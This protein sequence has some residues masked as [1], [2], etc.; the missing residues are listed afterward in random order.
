MLLGGIVI[1]ALFQFVFLPPLIPFFLFVI[2]SFWVPQIWRNARRG[3]GRA[4]D[5]TFVFGTSIGRLAL[6]LCEWTTRLFRLALEC[7]VSSLALDRSAAE[8]M[9]SLVANELIPTTLPRQ[10]LITDAF[11][12]EENVFFIQ[13]NKAVWG[14]VLWQ[15]LQIMMLLAQE[16][17]GPAFL[18]VTFIVCAVPSSPQPA[19]KCTP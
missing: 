5:H 13:S 10:A 19:Q 18:Y 6:P 9:W 3:N 1:I 4:L 8:T 15:V 11:S 7:A 14:L 12:Y 17:F 2:Y 16:R